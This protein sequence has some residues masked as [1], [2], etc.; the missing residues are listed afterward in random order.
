MK[1][2]VLKPI[3]IV[4]SKVSEPRRAGWEQVTSEIVVDESLTESLDG[5]EAF[6]H[7]IVVYWMHK[8]LYAGLPRGKI[9]PQGRE[10]LPL[11]GIFAT[12][13]PYRPNPL[14]VTVVRLL[15]RKGNVLRVVGLDAIDGTPIIDIKPYIPPFDSPPHVEVPDWVEKLNRRQP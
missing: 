5:L 2:M 13:T 7:I 6:S 3:G 4:R 11:V 10:D 15:K 1:E 9:H 14:G 12:R 8:V